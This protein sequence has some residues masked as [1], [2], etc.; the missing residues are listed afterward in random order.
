VKLLSKAELVGAEAE[1]GQSSLQV[2]MEVQ[3]QSAHFL[4]T[5]PQIEQKKE[6]PSRIV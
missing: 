6:L 3:R 5:G 2:S 4:H 1:V